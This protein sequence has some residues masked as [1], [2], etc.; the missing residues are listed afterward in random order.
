MVTRDTPWPPGTPCWVDVSTDDIGAARL[1]YEQLFGWQ[2]SEGGPEFGGYASCTKDGRA[3]AGLAPRMDPSQPVAWSTYLATTDID[4][5]FEAI[6]K[7]GGQVAVAPMEV[8]DL[9]RMGF[10][11]DPGGASFGVWQAGTHTGLQLAN[12]PGSLIW[13]ENMSRN[14]E[15]NKQF[16]ADVFGFAYTDMS[17][18]GFHYAVF[19]VDGSGGEENSIGGIGEQ[20][21]DET[22]PAEWGI[23]FAVDDADEA[24]N[25][26]VRLGG[27][28]I[29]PAWD[30][31]YGR[32]ATV[33]DPGGARF[34][35]MAAAPM[36]AEES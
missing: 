17:N 21:A 32:M 24:V 15:A 27:N 19:S 36:P 5:V 31:P 28:V 14:W 33:A 12:E 22:A 26:V 6:P 34:A 29:K 10:G 25:E 35:V 23:Y 16:Y 18:D 1:F 3:V 30:T 13:E 11:I 4:A 20:P 9:G 8:G 7:H 2:I